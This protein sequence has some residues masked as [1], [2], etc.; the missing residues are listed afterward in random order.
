MAT[1]Y[2]LCWRTPEGKRKQAS[3]PE[4]IREIERRMVYVL[5]DNGAATKREAQTFA[6]F[7]VRA[8]WDNPAIVV[9]HESNYS[10]TL[11]LEGT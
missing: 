7:A 6:S 1:T 11:V 2:T 3:E 5:S 9:M 10:F 8:W 4:T